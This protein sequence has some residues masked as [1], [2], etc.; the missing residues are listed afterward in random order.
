MWDDFLR[1]RFDSGWCSNARVFGVDDQ[2]RPETRGLCRP[3]K[4][5]R[6]VALVRVLG[7]SV[8]HR[9]TGPLR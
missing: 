6:C 8:G 3:Q 7:D 2:K 1:G 4:V 9:L 5:I